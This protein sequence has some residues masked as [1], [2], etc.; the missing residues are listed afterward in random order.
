MA[1]LREPKNGKTCWA[2]RCYK[3][4]RPD[5]L[6]C[7]AHAK[8]E[9]VAHSLYSRH[10]M[11]AGKPKSSTGKPSGVRISAGSGAPTAPTTQDLRDYLSESEE[12]APIEKPAASS[13]KDI[14]ASIG[15]L[16]EQKNTAYGNSFAKCGEFLRLLYPNGVQPE[17]YGDMLC[18]VRM[19]DKL[20]RIATDKN[21]FGEEPFKDLAGYALLGVKMHQKPA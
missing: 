15:E 11:A 21:A 20:M 13:Y 18:V 12:P 3:Q 4:H 6:T 1:A 14:G 2:E 7:T 9:G 19:F 10:H 16:V 17:Q 5:K 8:L